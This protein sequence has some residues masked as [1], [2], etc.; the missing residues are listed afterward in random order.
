MVFY[1]SALHYI[2]L[3]PPEQDSG[4]GKLPAG[5]RQEASGEGE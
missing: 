3:S 1:P 5:E 2:P 4:A